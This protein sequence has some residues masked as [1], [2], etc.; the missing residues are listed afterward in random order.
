MEKKFTL[1]IGVMI[2]IGIGT[3]IGIFTLCDGLWPSCM[4]TALSCG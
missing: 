3:L 2:V 1:F 4:R